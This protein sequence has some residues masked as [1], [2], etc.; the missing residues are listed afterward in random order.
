M[1]H[2]VPGTYRHPRVSVDLVGRLHP[3]LDGQGFSGPSSLF[4]DE[5][6]SLRALRVL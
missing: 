6:G 3:S 4:L 5:V 1:S 2:I